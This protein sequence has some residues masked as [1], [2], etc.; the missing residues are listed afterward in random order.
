[1]GRTPLWPECPPC[2][3]MPGRVLP[4]SALVACGAVPRA[5][6]RG[7]G[8][9]RRGRRAKPGVAGPAEP[10]N[11]GVR[12]AEVSSR[13]WAAL[14]ALRAGEP[15]HP[16]AQ[17]AWSADERAAWSLYA[18]LA[19][20]NASGWAVA[21]IGQS[22]DGRV[23][24]VSGDAR[25]ISGPGGLAHLHRLRALADAVVIGVRTALHDNPRLT[26][27]LVDGPSPARVII[28]PR[29]RLPDDAPALA[30]DGVRRI[31]IQ[32]VD[33]PRPSGVEVVQL[34]DNRGWIAPQAILRLMHGLGLRHLLI[35]GGG[36][37]ISGF[38]DAALLDRLHV[39]VAPLIIGAGPMSLRTAPIDR[40]ADALRPETAV[41]GLG[42]D[43]LFDCDVAGAK[44]SASTST[45]PTSHSA[46]AP[47]ASRR[48]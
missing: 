13:V 18:P 20:R 34:S 27:R 4:R 12:S 7:R 8:Q 11:H 15:V 26:V 36:I 21:Q 31:V 33:R 48:A 38:L 30:Q 25:D 23:A 39:A 6:W 29:A 19:R 45:C 28:D 41:Y 32:A 16:G 37:T 3:T 43:I 35:E 5:P 44:G 14:L 42:S 2:R 9:G 1:M 46:P 22:L 47:A 10:G 40:L 17:P 24:T